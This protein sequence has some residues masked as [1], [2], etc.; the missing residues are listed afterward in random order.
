MVTCVVCGKFLATQV[1]TR[2]SVCIQL[3][4]LITAVKSNSLPVESQS[5]VVGI[6][7]GAEEAI[8]GLDTGLSLGRTSTQ[9]SIKRVPKAQPARGAPVTQLPWPNFPP[10]PPSQGAGPRP[11]GSVGKGERAV[12]VS[13][14][15]TPIRPPLRS[16]G[17]HETHS[18][19]EA[20][21]DLEEEFSVDEPELE[22]GEEK[23]TGERKNRP[24][25]KQ[26][27][28]K[29]EALAEAGVRETKGQAAF[30]KAAAYRRR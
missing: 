29:R 16:V 17:V 18:E 23:V 27:R 10:V 11:R 15:R 3:Q 24:G 14:S 6:L 8:W 1:E 28:K 22:K 21:E 7:T 13:R 4:R 2:C 20:W 5:R 25:A 19:P 12:S 9:V 30:S 26:R